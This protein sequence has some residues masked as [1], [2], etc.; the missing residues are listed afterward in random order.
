MA[1]FAEWNMHGAVHDE[2][3]VYF[4]DSTGISSTIIHQGE[5]LRGAGFAGEIGLLPVTALSFQNGLE[6]LEQAASTPAIQQIMNDD[7]ISTK[8]ILE[9]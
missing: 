6:R 9:L 1:A 2:T 7:N 8:D 3:F 4:T 5:F